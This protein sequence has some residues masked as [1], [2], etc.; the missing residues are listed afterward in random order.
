MGN[1]RIRR[2]P[3]VDKAGMLK[4]IISL[5][6]LALEVERDERLAQALTDISKPG[7]WH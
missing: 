1:Q 7:T 3:I 4:G 6:D 2:L 5:G